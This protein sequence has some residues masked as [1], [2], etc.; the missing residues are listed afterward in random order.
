MIAFMKRNL[1]LYFRDKAGV[2]FSLLGVFIIIALYVFF[3]GD[4]YT[5]SWGDIDNARLIMDRW[6]MAG[7]LAVTS[8][9]TTLGMLGVMVT[10]EENHISKDFKVAPMKHSSLVLGYLLSAY[11]VGLIMSF[12]A[13]IILEIYLVANGGTLILGMTLIKT[14]GMLLLTTLMNSAIVMF[15]VSVFKTV[16]AYS[17]ASTVIGTLIGFLTGIYLPVGMYPAVVQMV[18]KTF[19]VS[20]AALILRNILMEAPM[21]AAMTGAPAEMVMEIKE[22]LGVVYTVGS[23]IVTT[24]ESIIY[25]IGVAILFYVLLCLNCK[26]RR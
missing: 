17:T 7:V 18:I 23:H 12:F 6:V 9:T 4:V 8:M 22:E 11:V 10:D 16:N 14:I 13:L 20:H 3:L 5:E 24:Q 19:P 15:L 2:F 25:M 21:N 1:K 26:K